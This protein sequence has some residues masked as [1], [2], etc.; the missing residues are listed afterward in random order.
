MKNVYLCFNM[1]KI[2]FLLALTFSSSVVFAYHIAEADTTD[3]GIFGSAAIP[4]KMLSAKHEWN[5]NNMRGALIIYREVLAMDPQNAQ[6]LYWTARCH[7]ALK[8]Y[9]LAQEYLD[10]SLTIDPKIAKD[11][12]FFQGQIYHRLAK[13]DKAMEAY[14]IYMKDNE[15]KRTYEMEQADQYVKECVFA[16]EMMNKPADV[17]IQNLGTTVNTRFDEYCPSI[18]ANG[19]L[20]V[21]TSR[22]STTVGG[23]IDEGSDYK[24]FE[25]VYYSRKDE[26]GSWSKAF[27]VD[28]EV[29]TPTYDA[30]L[31]IA[32]DGSQMFIY[33]NNQSSQGDIFSSSYDRHEDS[34]RAPEKLP[35]PVNTSYFESSASITADG[36]KLY[37]VSEREGGYGQGDIYVSEKTSAGWGKPKNLGAVVNTD[38]DEKFVFIHPNGKTLYFASNGHQC[39]GGHDIF[40]TEFLNGQW[41]IPVNLGYPINTVNEESTFSL[42]KDNK[43]MYIAAEYGDTYGERDIYSIDVSNYSLISAGYDSSGYGTLILSLKDAEGKVLKGEEVKITLKDTDRLIATQKSDRAGMVRINLPSGQRY[44]V[45]SIGKE[46]SS[47][48]VEMAPSSK[49]PEI[50]KQDFV[51]K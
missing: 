7:Y 50:V 31:S 12:S 45:E 15:G 16:K 41:S 24:Y 46:V 35:R 34:W 11:V 13:L 37:F 9:D 48:V 8:S 51:V 44:L 39:L 36:E 49:K 33:K 20:M 29:N 38:L 19:E 30:V 28:G 47:A 21:F 42:T 18:T 2:L 3:K 23:E 27:G 43:T 17:D 40:K 4:A 22:R 6:A 25:D 5:D 10:K 26:D 1:K 32:P 14:Q